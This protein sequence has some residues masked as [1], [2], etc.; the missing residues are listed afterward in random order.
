MLKP[1]R[2]D[3]DLCYNGTVMSGENLSGRS[4]RIPFFVRLRQSNRERSD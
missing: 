4:V 2:A 1:Q 3:Y